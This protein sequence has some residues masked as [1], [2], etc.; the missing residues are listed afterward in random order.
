[1]GAAVALTALCLVLM[2]AGIARALWVHLRDYN[3]R[4]AVAAAQLAA[5]AVQHATQPSPAP[6]VPVLI[7]HPAAHEVCAMA[8][9]LGPLAHLG[10]DHWCC[11]SIKKCS[12]VLDALV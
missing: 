2:M 9:K 5:E 1:M 7:L 4:E 11:T 6:V 3:E 8:P 10:V 12:D